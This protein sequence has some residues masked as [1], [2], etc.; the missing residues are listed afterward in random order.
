MA[1][2]FRDQARH[3]VAAYAN[4]AADQTRQARGKCEA[5]IHQSAVANREEIYQKI[6]SLVTSPSDDALL[7]GY[8]EA[9][10][11]IVF[12]CKGGSDLKIKMSLTIDEL[13]NRRF[14]VRLHYTNS[15]KREVFFALF[16]SI[17]MVEYNRDEAAKRYYE[18]EHS[19]IQAV[20]V[21]AA[22]SGNL[23]FLAKTFGALAMLRSLAPS[24]TLSMP[25]PPSTPLYDALKSGP[26]RESGS[27]D[28]FSHIR[29]RM[30]YG[31]DF[32]TTIRQRSLGKVI[33]LVQLVAKGVI[34]Q[35]EDHTGELEAMANPND[36]TARIFEYFQTSYRDAKAVVPPDPERVA[37]ERQGSPRLPR[38]NQPD[39][40]GGGKRQRI[41][42]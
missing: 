38:A 23:G 11:T 1:I 15:T 29:T 36:K 24:L 18:A 27:I 5:M 31:D 37:I 21:G 32:D 25:K 20:T 40:A 14:Q 4:S 30:A 39:A 17:I 28:V 8:C 2:T 7:V 42:Q 22:A 26:D 33:A 12:G 13:K 16:K 3:D 35:V 34:Q 10:G 19:A 6:Q 9:Y 41:E